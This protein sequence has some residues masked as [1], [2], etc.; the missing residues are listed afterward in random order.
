MN[1]D[2]DY[3]S[4]AELEALKQRYRAGSV[5]PGF[6]ARV[7]AMSQ[8]RHNKQY[9]QSPLWLGAG[10]AT[11]VVA[12]LLV[13]PLYMDSN[14]LQP[15]DQP[16]P[17]VVVRPKQPETTIP[18][19]Q[20][21]RRDDATSDDSNSRAG[22]SDTVVSAG[23]AAGEFDFDTGHLSDAA[24]WMASQE[25]LEMPDFSEI[26]SPTEFPDSFSTK[27]PSRPTHY[28]YRHY[29]SASIYQYDMK[30]SNDE[31]V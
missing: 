19:K 25:A 3:H 13:L 30:E 9:W 4:I 24:S 1:H 21:A 22:T 31:T 12:V 6:A 26:P 8:E 15:L 5:P 2:K 28:A 23:V 20:L 14:G 29:R 18:D 11:A 27:Q 10:I 17:S 7:S 16:G